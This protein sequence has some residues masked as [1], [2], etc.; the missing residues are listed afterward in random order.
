MGTVTL[1]FFNDFN[2]KLTTRTK[3]IAPIKVGTMKN[4]PISGPHE[5]KRFEPNQPPIKPAMMFPITPPGISLPII[6]PANQP[7]IPPTINVHSML[8][9]SP[10][11]KVI[12]VTIFPK[13][14]F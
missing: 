11:S 3:I 5:P 7:S 8:I 6:I 2:I 13:A 14:I 1:Y 9:H 4:P 12:Y 10:L